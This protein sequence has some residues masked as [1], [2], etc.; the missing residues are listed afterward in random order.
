M[1][2]ASS[3]S[4]QLELDLAP[5]LAPALVP[6]VGPWP[7]PPEHFI[8]Q[9]TDTPCEDWPG[10]PGPQ[11]YGQTTWLGRTY[12][13]HVI[14]WVKTYGPIPVETPR[15]MVLHTCDRPICVK[16][17]HLWLGT[18]SDNAADRDA[19][20]RAI[21]TVCRNGHDYDEANTGHTASG[22]RYCQACKAATTARARARKE[23]TSAFV[24][25]LFAPREA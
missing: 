4:E 18:N 17:E 20:D 3:A 16:P 25:S 15:L 10:R 8:G 23:A 13:A 2:P 6:L 5:E 1:D 11:G 12:G 7:T 14:A 19:K 21:R 9:R 24:A 22:R